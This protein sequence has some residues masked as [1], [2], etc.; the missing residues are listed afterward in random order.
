[1]CF[2]FTKMEPKIKVQFFLEVVFFS[3]KLGEIWAS[4]G[5][6]GQKWCLKC[7]VV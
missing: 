4:L 3:D 5:E 6:F 1:M 2:E 7:A